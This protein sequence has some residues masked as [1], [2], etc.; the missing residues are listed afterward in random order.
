MPLNDDTDS[1]SLPLFIVCALV[2]FK[3]ADHIQIG[4][5]G[6]AYDLFVAPAIH[7]RPLIC[8]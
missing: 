5:F 3:S 1:G 7:V 8:S 6:N 2:S 4:S